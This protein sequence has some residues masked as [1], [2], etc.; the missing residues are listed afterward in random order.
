[1]SRWKRV[2]PVNV[3]VI[4][5]GVFTLVGAGVLTFIVVRVIAGVVNGRDFQWGVLGAIAFLTVWTL[6]VLRMNRRGVWMSVRGVR[7]TTF[8]R[9]RTFAWAD[10][11]RFEFRADESLTGSVYNSEALWVVEKNG[12]AMQTTLFFR[13][14]THRSGLVGGAVDAHLAL[15]EATGLVPTPSR[16]RRIVDRLE[17]ARSRHSQQTSL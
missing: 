17:Q 13:G 15:G 2:T 12:R 7:D 16:V 11:D 5:S 8:L 3:F 9:S 1:V 6:C 4:V 14:P 10:I